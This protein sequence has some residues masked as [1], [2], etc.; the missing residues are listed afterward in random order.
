MTIRPKR[1][2]VKG[3]TDAVLAALAA[4]RAEQLSRDA[5]T[6]D[7]MRALDTF[8]VGRV[9]CRDCGGSAPAD[10][11]RCRSCDEV[12]EMGDARNRGRMGWS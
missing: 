9:A 12:A 4:M 7:R 10:T 8:G 1:G 6:L 3:S 5:E 2:I 11:K